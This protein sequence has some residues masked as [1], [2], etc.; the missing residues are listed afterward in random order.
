MKQ[1]IVS[2]HPAGSGCP[3]S[4]HCK[5]EESY[6]GV[7]VDERIPPSDNIMKWQAALVSMIDKGGAASNDADAEGD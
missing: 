3:S 4:L 5:K 1:E 7:G 2:A 6:F